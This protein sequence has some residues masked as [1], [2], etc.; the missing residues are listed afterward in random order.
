MPEATI[1]FSPA[2]AAASVN[3]TPSG[4]MRRSRMPASPSSRPGLPSVRS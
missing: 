2:I 4:H 1:A 3:D